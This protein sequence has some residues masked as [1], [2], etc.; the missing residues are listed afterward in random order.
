MFWTSG[1]HMDVAKNYSLLNLVIG[2][3]VYFILGYVNR[4]KVTSVCPGKI[5]ER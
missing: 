4:L 2:D 5:S 1:L 3:S